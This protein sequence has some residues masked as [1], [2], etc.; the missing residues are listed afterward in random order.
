MADWTFHPRFV[1]PFYQH[2][3]GGNLARLEP[4][5]RAALHAEFHARAAEIT[6]PELREMLRSSW[7]PSTV[8]A[9]FIAARR[10]VTL[11]AEVERFLIERPGHVAPASLCLAHLGGESAADVLSHYVQ[12][13]VDGALRSQP[14]DESRTPEWA[15]CAWSHLSGEA[16]EPRWA[17]FVDAEIGGL[18]LAGWYR[19]RPQFLVR[20]RDGWN[21]RF[22]DA[23]RGLPQMLSF[24]QPAG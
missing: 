23:R 19:D 13:C 3:M 7:R 12:D 24:V 16:P 5:G 21:A 18:G 2:L 1:S 10:S 4:A 14:C 15:L 6:E 17:A 8:A 9:W 20:L 22:E 11:Q